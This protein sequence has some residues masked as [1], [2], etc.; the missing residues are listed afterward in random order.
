MK[1]FKN[2]HR[3]ICKTCGKKKLINRDEECFWCWDKVN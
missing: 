3:G 2:T 1:L